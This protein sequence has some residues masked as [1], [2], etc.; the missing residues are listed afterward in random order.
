MQERLQGSLPFVSARHLL[1][2]ALDERILHLT[3]TLA[4][5]SLDFLLPTQQFDGEGS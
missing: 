2:F 5:V 1:P 4:Y 3:K